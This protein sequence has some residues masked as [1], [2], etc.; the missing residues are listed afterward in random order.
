MT[1]DSK[2]FDSAAPQITLEMPGVAERISFANS[3]NADPVNDIGS[4]ELN[5]GE[6]EE[7]DMNNVTGNCVAHSPPGP[8]YSSFMSNVS[9][10]SLMNYRGSASL[11]SKCVATWFNYKYNINACKSWH[12][13]HK[14]GH[15]D[16]LQP[17]FGSD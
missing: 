6:T 2:D 4:V 9:N 5:A 12:R 1:M 8:S 10:R 16:D 14:F 15:N 13:T 7:S 11:A 3:D 17:C